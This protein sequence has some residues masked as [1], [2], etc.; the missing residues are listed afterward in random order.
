MKSN[1]IYYYGSFNHEF[2]H[3]DLSDCPFCGKKDPFIK[4]VRSEDSF[5]GAVFCTCGAEMQSEARG[6]THGMLKI[7]PYE[8][9]MIKDAVKKWN[10]RE[11]TVS[12]GLK[13]DSNIS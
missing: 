6:F 11:I 3:D 5:F 12:L 10:K 4:I 13:T 9:A 1:L 2:E 7:E 8:V